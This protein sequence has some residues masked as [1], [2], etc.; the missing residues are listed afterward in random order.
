M[1][2]VDESVHVEDLEAKSG[3]TLYSSFTILKL[4]PWPNTMQIKLR[5]VVYVSNKTEPKC[6]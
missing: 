3:Y 5:T 6:L 2:K 1:E 4:I